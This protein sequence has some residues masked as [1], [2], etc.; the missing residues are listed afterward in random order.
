MPACQMPVAE[1]ITVKTDTARVQDQQRATLEFLLLNHPVDCAICDQAGECKLQDYY[2]KYDRQPSRLDVPKVEKDKRVVLGPTVV[3]DQERCILCT[4]CVR[5]MR[6]IA[7]APQLGVAERGNESRITTF[8][9]QPLDNPYAG[10]VVDICPVGALTSTDFR[11]RGRVWF[12]SAA[13]SVC[14]G[15]SRGCNTYL[16]Y[17]NDTVYRYRPR[18]ND[19]VN[20]EWM[21]DAGRGSYKYLNAPRVLASR[22]G[23]GANA[24][25]VPHEIAVTRAA[26]TL[27]AASK[28]GGLAALFSPVASLEDLLA[29][30]LV[31][32]DGLGITDVYV[33]GRADGWQDDFLKRADENPNGRG[34][35]LVAQAFGLTLRPYGELAKAISSGAVKALWAVGSEVPVPR[36]DEPSAVHGLETVVVQAFNLDSIARDATVL[37]PAAPHSEADGTFVNFEGLPQ[38]FELAFWPRG[39]SLP[40]WA[41]AMELG[42]ALGLTRRFTSAR[43]V[44]EELSP[45]L[46]GA[47]GE[48]AWD[49]LPSVAKRRGILPLA[50]GT[51]D[52]RL[53]GYRERVPPETSEDMKRAINKVGV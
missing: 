2:M 45:R 33:G 27:R 52:G 25:V 50:A 36:G 19:K 41:L 8:P 47:L 34:L 28:A 24:R 13:R 18:E 3:L 1:G 11:F 39:E 26:E 9:G 14:T 6:E 23:R 32:K 5:F 49:S 15:C 29:A 17:L 37:L 20:Q 43:Q 16:D 51:V 48:F 44:F 42:R 22:E 46:A 35:E 53:P 40:H 12:M 38:R 10:N 4:R 21:C 31:A 30:A 7:K